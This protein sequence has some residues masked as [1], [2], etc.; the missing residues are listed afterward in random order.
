MESFLIGPN[1]VG[2]IPQIDSGAFVDPS[3]RI[4][5][6]VHISSGCYVG[7]QA[8][9]R[10]DEV[11][12]DGKV[13]PIIIGEN[14]NIQDGVT[15]HALAGASVSIG[16]RCSIAHGAVIHGPCTVG[17]SCFI[18]FRSVI[19]SSCLEPEVFVGI[20]AVV[21]STD[22]P[23]GSLVPPSSVVLSEH[24]V[25]KTVGEIT[26]SE[27]EFMTEVVEMNISLTKGYKESRK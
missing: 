6:N 21:Q 17:D 7:P 12:A 25:K 19:F 4:I 13:A 3:A 14:S 23:G 1:T 15:I 11:D 26:S 8:V 20:S 18:G 2:D 9:I 24:D 27:R 16:R 10:A 5:G 22:L